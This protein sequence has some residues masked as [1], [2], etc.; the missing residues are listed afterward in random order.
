MTTKPSKGIRPQLKAF[1]LRDRALDLPDRP[2]MGSIRDRI[3]GAY[4][5]SELEQA[6][7]TIVPG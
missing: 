5:V 6:M 4:G 7:K 2:P 1:G 3:E